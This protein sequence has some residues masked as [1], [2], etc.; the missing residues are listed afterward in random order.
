MKHLVL[1]CQ[2][3]PIIKIY[4]CLSIKMMIEVQL[5][6]NLFSSLSVQ[7]MSAILW[8][9]HLSPSLFSPQ[10]TSPL[11]LYLTT[12]TTATASHLLATMKSNL[13]LTIDSDRLRKE[14]E[15]GNESEGQGEWVTNKHRA[16]FSH[17]S[18]EVLWNMHFTWMWKHFIV[19]FLNFQ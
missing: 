18:A 13:A 7:R 2:N 4:I 11:P 14:N 5:N 10:V 15:T 1:Y 9:L 16:L 12:S 17:P 3:G 6:T 19:L 8:S